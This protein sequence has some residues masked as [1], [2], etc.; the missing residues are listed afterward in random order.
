MDRHRPRRPAPFCSFSPQAWGWTVTTHIRAFAHRVFP[1]GVGVDRDRPIAA[2]THRR[3][4]HRRGGGPPAI[5][6]QRAMEGFSPQ[7]WGWTVLATNRFD[8]LQVF[9]TGVGVDRYTRPIIQRFDR[10]PHRRGGGPACTRLGCP[11]GLFSP[12]AW[13]WTAMCAVSSAG[14]SVFPTGVGV[15]RRLR[16]LA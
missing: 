16:D 10:F 11:T 7:A 8:A 3:F 9:P 12:Q 1:T 4:P 5:D 6:A 14:S 13:G 2:A 15:D